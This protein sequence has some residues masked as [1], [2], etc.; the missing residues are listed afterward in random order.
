M[1]TFQSGPIDMKTSLPYMIFAL[2]CLLAAA[3]LLR[4][5]LRVRIGLRLIFAGLV[6]AAIAGVAIALGPPA[7]AARLLS[8][9]MFIGMGFVVRGIHLDKARQSN[10]HLL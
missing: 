7:I 3:W 10:D 5:H 2:A 4:P 8:L 1:Q 9:P 6:V